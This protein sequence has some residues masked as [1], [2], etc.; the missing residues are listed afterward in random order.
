[1]SVHLLT[2][3]LRR[4][5]KL[6]DC[7][8]DPFPDLLAFHV[9]LRQQIVGALSGNKRSVEP[10]CF[11]SNAGAR[12]TSMSAITCDLQPSHKLEQN[13]NKRQGR[14]WAA[15]SVVGQFYAGVNAGSLI[16]ESISTK[17]TGT[18]GRGDAD[19]FGRFQS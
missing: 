1:V 10:G 11:T 7:F 2:F 5:Q 19:H 14:R 6:F 13:T 18:P 12:H 8:D 4:S 9:A 15:P 16:P 17:Q 3:G